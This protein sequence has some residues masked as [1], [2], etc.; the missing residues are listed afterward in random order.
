MTCIP[1]CV[2]SA[3]SAVLTNIILS[4]FLFTRAPRWML[5]GT[6]CLGMLLQLEF[7]ELELCWLNCQ[8]G[9]KPTFTLHSLIVHACKQPVA[10]TMTAHNMSAFEFRQG[11]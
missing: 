2:H 3:T 11:M 4:L 9:T 1:E 10:M 8:I 6:L 7:L 5:A